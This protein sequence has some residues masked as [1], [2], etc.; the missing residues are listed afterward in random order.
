MGWGGISVFAQVAGLISNTDL[1]F[2]RFVFARIGHAFLAIIYSKLF[3]NILVEPTSSLPP[4]IQALPSWLF[5]F[6]IS[7]VFFLLGTGLLLL[8]AFVFYSL[9]RSKRIR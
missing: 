3:L 1:R 2:S 4:S 6:Q 9:D 5:T 7:T 8:L